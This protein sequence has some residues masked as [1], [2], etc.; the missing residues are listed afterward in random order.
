MPTAGADAGKVFEFEHDGFEFIERAPSLL[1]FLEQALVPGP[2]ELAGMA[3]HM[4]FRSP[5]SD[6]QWWIRE[7]RDSQG[8]VVSVD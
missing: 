6:A 7:M 2:G 4:R 1:A 8:R 3:S 5:D